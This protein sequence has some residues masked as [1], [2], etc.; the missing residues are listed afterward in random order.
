MESAAALARFQALLRIPTVSRSEVA[1]TDWTAFAA[2]R[3]ELAR[4]FPLAHDALERETVHEHTLLWRWRGADPGLEPAILMA[5]QDVVDP[6]RLEDWIHPAFDAEI[7][8]HDGEDV[9]WGRGTADDKGSLVAI[10][11]AVETLLGEGAAPRRDVWL[12]LGHDEETHGTGAAATAAVLADRGIRPAFVLDEGGAIVRDF[13]PGLVKPIAAVGVAEKGVGNY[14]V[15][16]NE[17]GGHSSAPPPLSAIGRLA[18]AVTRIDAKPFRATLP[19]PMREMFRAAGRAATG[20]RGWLYRNVA[21]TAPVLLAA[22][23]STSPE[24]R[25]MTGTSRVTTTIA[26]GH[27]QNAIPEHAEAIV[28][29]RIAPGE[30]LQT[31]LEHLRRAVDDPQVT[32]ELASGWDPSPVA[33]TEGLGWTLL[34]ETLAELRP[35]VVLAPYQQNGATDSRSFTGLTANVYRFT[36]FELSDGERGALHAVNERIRVD[37]WLGGVAFYRALLAKL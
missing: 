1:E 15:A 23:R 10:L 13:L 7:I 21:V 29:A 28:N 14:R 27:A 9:V 16:V 11:C 12:V 22:L 37:S 6:G 3:D 25:A 36:P 26:G 31:V 34:A 17:Q 33:P 30:T 35:D 32:V 8:E 4:Q 5:H 2:F 20:A 18:R 24:S 19:G